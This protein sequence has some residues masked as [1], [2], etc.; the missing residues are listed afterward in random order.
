MSD[1]ANTLISWQVG[2]SVSEGC[3]IYEMSNVT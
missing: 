3:I 1:N 2:K